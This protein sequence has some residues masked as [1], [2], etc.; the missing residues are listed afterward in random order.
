MENRFELIKQRSEE[1]KAA[2]AKKRKGEEMAKH[3]ADQE[4]EKV[5]SEIKRMFA[6][7]GYSDEKAAK[8]LYDEHGIDMAASSVA[9]M[10][11]SLGL[12]KRKGR[13]GKTSTKFKGLEETEGS[14][15]AARGKGGKSSFSD[16]EEAF[17]NFATKFEE[18]RDRRQELIDSL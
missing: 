9:L 10:R 2:Q 11:T 1:I 15:P 12:K 16:V 14:P 4:R 6:E 8:F 18:Y 7:D 3:M 5:E 17:D 13:R